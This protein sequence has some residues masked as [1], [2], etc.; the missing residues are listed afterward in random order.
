MGKLR[1]RKKNDWAKVPE[2]VSGMRWRPCALMHA[3]SPFRVASCWRSTEPS[4]TRLNAERLPSVSDKTAGASPSV[5]FSVAVLTTVKAAAASSHDHSCPGQG[6]SCPRGSLCC[7]KS[8]VIFAGILT[9]SL[10]LH[11]LGTTFP[12]QHQHHCLQGAL[13]EAPFP[14]H[15]PLLS[16]NHGSLLQ[17]LYLSL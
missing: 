3:G 17:S 13:P 14:A 6:G 12:P 1:L 8:R 4:K 15:I 11:G 16:G 9:S 2:N 5:P 10:P 7:L